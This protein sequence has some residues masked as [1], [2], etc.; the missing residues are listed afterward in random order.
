MSMV[1]VLAVSRARRRRHA[2]L[3]T[4]AAQSTPASDRAGLAVSQLRPRSPF[5]PWMPAV[6][7]FVYIA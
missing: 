4:E 2:T 1:I 3:K 7:F 5:R 6:T